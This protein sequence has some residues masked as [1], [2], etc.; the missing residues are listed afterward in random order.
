MAKGERMKYL[1]WMNG[2]QTEPMSVED[3]VQLFEQD[4][5]TATTLGFPEDGAGDWTPINHFPEIVQAART[6]EAAT[7]IHF[8]NRPERE[9]SA[10]PPMEALLDKDAPVKFSVADVVFA[11]F[12]A[13]VMIG[14]AMAGRAVAN[15]GSV[16]AGWLIFGAGLTLG[17]LLLGIAWS[18]RLLHESIQRTRRLEARLLKSGNRPPPGN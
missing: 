4:R 16:L 14:A 3:I 8:L 5:I 1:L 7:T 18:I 13:V 9:P 2:K 11:V 6:M 12:G 17:L 15:E 10:G